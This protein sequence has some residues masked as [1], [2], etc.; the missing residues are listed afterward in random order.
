MVTASTGPAPESDPVT[1]SV[2]ITM[3]GGSRD[4]GSE[5]VMVAADQAMYRAK[6]GHCVHAFSDPKVVHS[7][8][9]LFFL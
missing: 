8:K 1:I 6:R 5:A 9:Y 3:F 7:G 4:G 2:G